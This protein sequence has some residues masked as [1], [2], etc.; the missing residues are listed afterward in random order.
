MRAVTCGVL[1]EACCVAPPQFHNANLIMY[2]FQW[3]FRFAML[4]V[5]P[6]AEDVLMDSDEFYQFHSAVSM[7]AMDIYGA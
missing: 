6:P 3:C 5:L 7:R 1:T 2:L 4:A